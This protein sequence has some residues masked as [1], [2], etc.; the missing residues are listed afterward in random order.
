MRSPGRSAKGGTPSTVLREHGRAPRDNRC[1]RPEANGSQ[2]REYC[3]YGNPAR[4]RTSVRLSEVR[5]TSC[6]SERTLSELTP[7]TFADAT[8]FLADLDH[9]QGRST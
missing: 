5:H 9:E 7:R 8:S 1:M 2:P 3:R 4:S 6:P